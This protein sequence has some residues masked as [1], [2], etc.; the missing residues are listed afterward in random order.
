MRRKLQ[1]AP[2]TLISQLIEE[3][4]GRSIASISQDIEA[5]AITAE[6]AIAL[7]VAD[8]SPALRITRR[9]SDLAGIAFEVSQSVHP[10]A[11]Y[12]LSTELTRATDR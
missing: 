1:A 6:L 4:D 10:G 9:Y 11:R 2:E 3:Y 12:K 7:D 5:I 8:G